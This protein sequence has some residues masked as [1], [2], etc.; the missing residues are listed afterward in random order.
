MSLAIDDLLPLPPQALDFVQQRHVLLL[1]PLGLGAGGVALAAHTLD[2]LVARVGVGPALIPPV[3]GQVRAPALQQRPA[4]WAPLRHVSGHRRHR[5]SRRQVDPLPRQALY[6]PCRRVQRL[7][8]TIRTRSSCTQRC[9]D[10]VP[11][12]LL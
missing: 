12:P 3:A 10:R 7:A 9:A 8:D 2:S 6:T 4:P 1:P 5:L 11:L